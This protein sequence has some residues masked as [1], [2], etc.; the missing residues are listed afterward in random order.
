MFMFWVQLVF[1]WLYYFLFGVFL[2]GFGRGDRG[3][4]GVKAGLRSF[5]WPG[6][7][8]RLELPRI[9]PSSNHHGEEG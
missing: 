6:L 4:G 2:V 7:D 9:R 8:D 3:G 5:G 1:D